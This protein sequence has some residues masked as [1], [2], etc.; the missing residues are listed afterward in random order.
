MFARIAIGLVV[1]AG[2]VTGGAAGQSGPKETRA[3]GD[4]QPWLVIKYNHEDFT[5]KSDSVVSKWAT[6]EEAKADAKKRNEAET[7]RAKWTHA[8]SRKKDE[9]AAGEKKQL[10][11][12]VPKL[13]ARGV[14][15]A[16]G[17]TNSAPAL[18]GKAAKGTIGAAKVNIKFGDGKSDAVEITG[19][20]K[21]EGKYKQIGQGVLIETAQARYR[22]KYDGK[23]ATG[24]RLAIEET[25]RLVEW[26]VSFDQDPAK[27]ATGKLEP[28]GAAD[29]PK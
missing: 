23:K 6:E 20:E 21:S 19:D 13:Q 7:D 12:P 16:A 29:P 17:E 4:D 15:G 11:P 8:F 2:A 5:G 22:G 1:F 25:E 28:K 9:A 14:S 24:V 26:T 10:A 18:A 3:L 27:P